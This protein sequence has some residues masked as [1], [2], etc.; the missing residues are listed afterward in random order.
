VNIS[1]PTIFNPTDDD[2]PP[3]SVP[4]IANAADDDDDASTVV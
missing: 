4:T 3:S 2:A 1:N